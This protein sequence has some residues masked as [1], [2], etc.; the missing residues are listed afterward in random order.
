MEKQTKSG[1]K[2]KTLEE[3]ETKYF[4]K[5]GT[6]K[7]ERYESQIQVEIIGELIKQLRK[8]NRLTQTQLAKRLGMDKAYVS[9]IENN[10]KTQRL[11]TILRILKVL[12][13]HLFIRIPNKGG[14]KEVELI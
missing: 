3:L 5:R 8:D 7:R 12:K 2:T 9:R 6:T 4:G 1:K 14:Q 11:D 13:G 10:L